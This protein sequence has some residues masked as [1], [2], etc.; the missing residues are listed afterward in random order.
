MSSGPSSST[1]PGWRACS[2]SSS[3]PSGG[4]SCSGCGLSAVACAA[5]STGLSAGISAW[6][7]SDAAG[8]TICWPRIACHH[9]PSVIIRLA[10]DTAPG[11][12]ETVRERG[13][14]G[15]A[16]HR[17]IPHA[18]VERRYPVRD[19]Q[20]IA[21]PRNRVNSSLQQPFDEDLRKLA[22]VFRISIHEI[23]LQGPAEQE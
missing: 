23:V 8:S 20:V 22:D 1:A 13:S 21:C 11:T 7:G 18:P 3:W 6:S 19:Y 15:P 12:T 9:S 16:V 14:R 17:S 4:P 5:T 2:S 10:P